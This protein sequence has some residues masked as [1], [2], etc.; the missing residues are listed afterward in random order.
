MVELLAKMH[1][2]ETL[3]RRSLSKN[4]GSFACACVFVRRC[5]RVQEG[6]MVQ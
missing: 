6:V 2:D 3:E 5:L 4:Q 1:S